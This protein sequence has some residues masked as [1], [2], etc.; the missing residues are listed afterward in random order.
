[1]VDVQVGGYGA[2]ALPILHVGSCLLRKF[3]GVFRAAAGALAGW[4]TVFGDL[5]LDFW[6]EIENLPRLLVPRAV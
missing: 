6:R 5:D 1:M 2:D 4:S 3:G